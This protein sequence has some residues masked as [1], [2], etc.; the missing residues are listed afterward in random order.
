MQS[1]NEVSVFLRQ[2]D[3]SKSSRKRRSCWEGRLVGPLDGRWL[4]GGRGRGERKTERERDGRVGAKSKTQARR[5]KNLPRQ[6]KHATTE[7]TR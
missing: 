5:I 7:D 4:E 3:S 2:C 1:G 6:Y